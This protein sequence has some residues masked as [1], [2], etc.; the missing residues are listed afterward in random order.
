MKTTKLVFIAIASLLLIAPGCK[1]KNKT[2]E[3]QT[4]TQKAVTTHTSEN[5]LDWNGIYAGVLPCA[6]CE[7]IQ[8][9]IV[10]NNN[11]EYEM[12]TKYLG[13]DNNEFTAN[14]KFEWFD[15]GSK[16]RLLNV[17]PDEA[18]S[19]YQVG[20]NQLI[21]LDLQGKKVDGGLAQNYHMTKVSDLLEKYWKLTEIDGKK[22]EKKDDATREAHM[23][24]KLDNNRVNGSGGCNSFNGG[25]VIKSNEHISFSRMAATMM[26]CQDMEVEGKFFKALEN[27]K[28]YSVKNDVLELKNDANMT[29]AKF[30][31]VYL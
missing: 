30:E 20:E 19:M 29:V 5:S 9:T 12:R 21:Q 11:G 18:P 4:Q 2:T 13:K 15:N 14:G 1:K 8:T 27:A 6:D 24:L 10:L 17:N 7:G 23:I 22:V 3:T 25:Y 16:I 28:M 31:A 26:A